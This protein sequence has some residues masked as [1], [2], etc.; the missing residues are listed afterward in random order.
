MEERIIPRMDKYNLTYAVHK[1]LL[2]LVTD[3]EFTKE[4]F[5]EELDRI[6]PPDQKIPRFFIQK[7]ELSF[8]RTFH[9]TSQ[10]LPMTSLAPVRSFLNRFAYGI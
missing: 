9:F 10:W 1:C 3:Q 2:A 8:I 6:C 4:E 5:K 7:E